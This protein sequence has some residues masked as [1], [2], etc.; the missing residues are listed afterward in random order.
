MRPARFRHDG[1]SGAQRRAT[2]V[3]AR[4][5]CSMPRTMSAT[6]DT[7][8]W[9][10]FADMG[11]VRHAEFVIERGEDV[12]VWDTEGRRYLDATASLW[13]ANVGHGRPEIAAAIAAQLAQDR[14]VLGVRRLRQPAG[15]RARRGARRARADAGARVFLVSGGG[16][17]IDT[18]AKLARRY[19]YEL[20]QPERTV[21]IS[22]TAGYHGTHG[23]GTAIGRDR[24]QPR[25][26]RAAARDRSRSATTRSTTIARRDRADRAGADRRRV[27][28][29]GD[30]RRRR[31]PAA[32]RATS[33]ASPS[34]ARET[35]VLFVIDSVIC[36]FG[37][38]G[39]WFGI[40]RWDVEA[41]M[42]IVR[43]GR[44]ERLSAA[45]RRDRLRAGSP[46]RS[47]AAPGGTDLPPRPH[48]C[49]A[50]DL[51]RGGARQHRAAR[52]RRAAHPRARERA[53]A[54]R[55]ARPVRRSRRGRRG[56]RRRRA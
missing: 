45:R 17:A 47:G 11:A 22:R 9:H 23:F 15:A 19:W 26:V 30:R 7:R 41:D 33:R 48:V 39:T 21:L 29:A 53:G 46:S 16:D 40:E 5:P 43:Q 14:G 4:L 18:A 44:H 37:R 36:G 49:R 38:L 55:R 50:R 2:A 52:A 8:L 6:S 54:V 35:G 31:L 12:W 25:G 42:I 10:P 51:L 24:R 13:Y 28:R 20:G 27:R 3:H 56:P 1:E 34:C 32:P